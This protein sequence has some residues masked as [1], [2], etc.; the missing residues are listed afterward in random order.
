MSFLQT[1]TAVT[2]LSFPSAQGNRQ[3]FSGWYP[4]EEICPREDSQVD[5]A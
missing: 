1:S 3:Y 5:C 4:L 2:V